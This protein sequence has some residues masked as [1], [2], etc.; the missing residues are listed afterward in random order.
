MRYAKSVL[1]S[2]NKYKRINTMQINYS[3]CH[4][5]R[6]GVLGS[7]QCRQFQTKLFKAIVI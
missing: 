3:K 2:P 4:N 5:K 1:L 7:N 6:L